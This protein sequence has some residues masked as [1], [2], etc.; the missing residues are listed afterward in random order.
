MPKKTEFYVHSSKRCAYVYSRFI[1][2][3]QKH[4]SCTDH[5][6]CKWKLKIL[7]SPNA[8]GGWVYLVFISKSWLCI[9]M[10]LIKILSLIILIRS[11]KVSY[12]HKSRLKWMKWNFSVCGKLIIIVY[13]FMLSHTPKMCDGK[14][15]FSSA[16]CHL[17]S[18]L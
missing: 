11:I 1:L 5:E 3:F 10:R 4:P 14:Q 6:T 8:H 17:K 18:N 12:L 13:H 9:Q 2:Y 16:N 7:A 15:I